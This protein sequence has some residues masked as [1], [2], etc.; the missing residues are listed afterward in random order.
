MQNVN[1][2]AS[3]YMLILTS[4]AQMTQRGEAVGDLATNAV[5]DCISAME[6][7][8]AELPKI[9]QILH[10]KF[11]SEL[12]LA[13]PNQKLYCEVLEDALREMSRLLFQREK[14]R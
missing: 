2:I 5:R 9:K 13:G 11:E 12:K 4:I 8:G 3:R 14:E 6:E 10:E 7:A 1:S